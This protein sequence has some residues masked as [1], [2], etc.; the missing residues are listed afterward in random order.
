MTCMGVLKILLYGRISSYAKSNYMYLYLAYEWQIFTSMST[1]C[2]HVGPLVPKV[3]TIKP[4]VFSQKSAD[5]F[6]VKFC[7][8]VFAIPC[9]F[10]LLKPFLN[11]MA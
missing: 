6:I 3:I 11:L 2:I 10:F 1:G 9:W 7:N 4:V 8:A 5:T